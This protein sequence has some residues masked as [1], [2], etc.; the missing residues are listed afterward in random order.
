MDKLTPIHIVG[1]GIGGLTVAVALIRRGFDVHVHEAAKSYAHVGGGHWLYANALHTLTQI[2][3]EIA[4]DMVAL[5]K[6]FDGFCFTTPDKRRMLFETTAPYTPS[7]E[8]APIVI[9]RAD[10]INQLAKRV[11][12]DRLHFGRRLT[13]CAAKTLFFEDGTEVSADVIIGADGIHSIVRRDRLDAPDARFS[14]QIGL[15]GISEFTLPADTGRLFTEMW[16]D[17]IRMGFTYVGTKGVYW[18]MVVRGVEIPTDAAARK[19]LIL[20]RGAE[21]PPEMVDVVRQTD[22]DAIHV[23]P[24]YDVA[25]PKRW[26]AGNACCIGDAVHAC[27]PNLGQ[28]GCQAIE[29]AWVLAQMLDAHDAAPTAFEAFQRTR[30]RK[31]QAVVYLSRWLGELA[32]LRGRWTGIARFWVLR[33]TPILFIRP[34]LRW[35]MR[36]PDNQPS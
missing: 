31:A 2:D 22:A 30:M 6:R 35:I 12:A 28:G 9:H 20:A 26:H 13:R 32:Q 17:G 4:A 21:F 8:L 24:L 3:P 25:P 16:G 15:W 5:G 33:L 19:N 11:P 29:D 27:T 7:P 14:G 1:G 10:I 23:N 34:V 36:P 18:F